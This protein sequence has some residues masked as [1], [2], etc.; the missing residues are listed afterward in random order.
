MSH[1]IEQ[2]RALEKRLSE[3]KGSDR[4]A[5]ISL[6]RI[7]G[8]IDEAHCRDWCRQDGRTDLTRDRYI[9]AWAP[10]YLS[11]TDAAVVLAERLT[12][13]CWWQLNRC[14]NIDVEPHVWFY[15]ACIM[16]LDDADAKHLA[17]GRTPAH[18]LCLA[19]V[20]ALIAGAP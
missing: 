1:D 11:S 12:D 19:T 5:E 6:Y 17:E 8:A 14:V 7:S 2:L 16:P 15:E 9:R 20:R 10:Q 13:G 4:D 3:I 18:A